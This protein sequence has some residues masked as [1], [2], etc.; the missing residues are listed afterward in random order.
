MDDLADE[1]GNLTVSPIPDR[2]RAWFKKQRRPFNLFSE[3]SIEDVFIKLVAF[4]ERIEAALKADGV[5]HRVGECTEAAAKDMNFLITGVKGVGKTS[6]ARGIVDYLNGNPDHGIVGV[7]VD[8]EQPEYSSGKTTM[9]ATLCQH[10]RDWLGARQAPKDADQA[11]EDLGINPEMKVVDLVHKVQD[12]K[13]SFFIVVD[14]VQALY[15]RHGMPDREALRE[16]VYSCYQLGKDAWNVA[17]IITGSSRKT[18]RLAYQDPVLSP[19]YNLLKAGYANL[20]H[21]VYKLLTIRPVRDK[22][23]LATILGPPDASDA[24]TA[25]CYFESGGVGRYLTSNHLPPMTALADDMLLHGAF[26]M[27]IR[28]LWHNKLLATAEDGSVVADESAIALTMGNPWSLRGLPTREAHA[29]LGENASQ[30]L[31]FLVDCGLLYCELDGVSVEF[32]RACDA[33]ALARC[34]AAHLNRDHIEAIRVAHLLLGSNCAGQD[35]LGHIVEPDIIRHAAKM[36]TLDP[37]VQMQLHDK[38]LHK[39]TATEPI[40]PAKLGDKPIETLDIVPFN[41]V[42]QMS[43]ERGQDGIWLER[44]D[45]RKVIVHFVQVKGGVRDESE[46]PFPCGKKPTAT[47]DTLVT[48]TYRMLTRS[49]PDVKALLGDAAKASGCSLVLGRL[50]L[51]TTRAVPIRFEKQFR[52]LEENDDMF[53]VDGVRRKLEIVNDLSLVVDEKHRHYYE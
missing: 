14:E 45:D 11:F 53:I 24:V 50:V 6:M 43:S 13:L 33:V 29:T 21:T 38:K 1:V 32:L 10:V 20:N 39:A 42:L 5:I 9:S 22:A 16:M 48:V 3:K 46:L 52:K 34:Y 28:L 41:T 26:E 51:L 49:W 36:F 19:D 12:A 2:V 4:I 15:V 30:K 35:S 47:G 8:C 23:V 27:V 44:E 40:Q 18:K 17:T 25:C 37:N 7:Y 31:D